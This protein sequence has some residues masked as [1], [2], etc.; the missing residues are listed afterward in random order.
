MEREHDLSAALGGLG[1]IQRSQSELASSV[2][3]LGRQMDEHEDEG[4]RK[5]QP[6]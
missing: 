3:T 6:G 1:E 4:S 2:D 5:G